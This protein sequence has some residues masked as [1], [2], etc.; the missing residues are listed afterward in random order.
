M[1]AHKNLNTYQSIRDA[2]HEPGCPFCCLLK[3]HQSACLQD[4][5]A[6]EIRSIC[7]YHA[8]GLAAVQD[9]P[10]A[11][12]VF[13]RLID[14]MHP[15]LPKVPC[16][17]CTAVAVEEGLR[18]REFVSCVSQ[19][20]VSS[21]LKGSEAVICLPHGTKLRRQLPLVWTSRLEAIMESHRKHLASELRQLCAEP[22]PDRTGWGALGRAAEFLVSQRGL[23]S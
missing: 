22:H 1:R 7:N 21:W 20:D 17:V 19:L 5:S 8:W 12:Q 9:A 11:A 10:T 2:L 4:H 13:I 23:H 6:R 18:I 14:G 3:E 16:D 15:V